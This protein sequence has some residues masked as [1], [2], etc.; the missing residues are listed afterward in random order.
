[1]LLA[2]LDAYLKEDPERTIGTWRDQG[3][4]TMTSRNGA[5]F[6]TNTE[7]GMMAALGLWREIKYGDAPKAKN[8]TRNLIALS[9][10]A[11]IDVWAARLLDRVAGKPRIPVEA[12]GA[13]SGEHISEKELWKKFGPEN[14]SATPTL[15]D[16][17]VKGQF[18]FG[19]EV[20][21]DVAA[22]MRDPASWVG[23]GLSAETIAKFANVTAADVQATNWFV[24]KE[25]WTEN[26][27]TND[28]GSGGS[29]MFEIKQMMGAR[30]QAGIS[31]QI[32]GVPGVEDYLPQNPEQARFATELRGRPFEDDA[33]CHRA[34]G[35]G[36][37]GNVHGSE[38]S[39]RLD[40]E[41]V[42]G[43][44]MEPND[45]IRQVLYHAW[46]KDQAATHISR[47]ITDPEEDVSENARPGIEVMFKADVELE[48]HQRR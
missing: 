20:F 21:D 44:G 37:P 23:S 43:P 45:V 22:R 18:A 15:G 7:R 24:E 28:E 8:F 40:T 38:A 25:I 27:W 16:L 2:E 14:L 4:A 5:L 31:Q 6:G 36:Q 33:R 35:D 42:H 3:G 39:A 10:R 34:P 30:F 12:E 1:M 13:V 32:S 9:I 29:F 46:S 26:N 47:V 17:P 41:W 11:T 19:Q 48:D